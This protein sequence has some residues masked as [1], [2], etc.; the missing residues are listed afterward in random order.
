ML[1]LRKIEEWKGWRGEQRHGLLGMKVRSCCMEYVA[2]I[3]RSCAGEMVVRM[4][5]TVNSMPQ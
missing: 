3:G 5:W 4:V 2:A 1:P